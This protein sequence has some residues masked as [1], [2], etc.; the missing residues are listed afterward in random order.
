[1]ALGR[2]S[3]VARRRCV[4]EGHDCESLVGVPG[5]WLLVPVT[6]HD[7]EKAGRVFACGPLR[8]KGHCGAT[9]VKGAA[10]VCLGDD[11]P[12]QARRRARKCAAAATGEGSLWGH[13]GGCARGVGGQVQ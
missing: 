6:G 11:G 13:R 9:W 4:G 3:A 10:A 8:G 2:P 1:M 12:C 5:A 7:C